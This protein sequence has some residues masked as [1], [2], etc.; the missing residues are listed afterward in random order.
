MS[1]RRTSSPDIGPVGISLRTDFRLTAA[2]LA[3]LFVVFEVAF[4]AMVSSVLARGEVARVSLSMPA[5][6]GRTRS[7]LAVTRR[8]DK[9]L[10]ASTSLMSRDPAQD[11]SSL[12]VKPTPDVWSLWT[13]GHGR[14]I[15]SLRRIGVNR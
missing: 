12:S 5:L 11:A 14:A 15:A 2:F 10:S 7:S 1:K 8:E 9:G 6:G 13:T 3:R 4:T